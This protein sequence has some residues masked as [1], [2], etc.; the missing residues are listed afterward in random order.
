MEIPAGRCDDQNV[1]NSYGSVVIVYSDLVTK[2]EDL[3]EMGGPLM[4]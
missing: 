3:V 1:S 4:I 2:S